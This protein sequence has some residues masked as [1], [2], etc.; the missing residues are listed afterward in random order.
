MTELYKKGLLYKGYTI[1]PYSPAAGTGLS[2]HELNQ[3]GCYRDVKDTTCTALVPKSIRDEK[4]E[5]L[6][7][8]V[9]GDRV[10]HGMDDHTLDVALEYRAGCG[11]RYPLRTRADVTIPIRASSAYRRS[12]QVT[13]V[14]AY[15][16]KK[17]EELPIWTA[18]TATGRTFRTGS[19]GEF[20]G[21]ELP[22]IRVRAADSVDQTRWAM[23]S[24]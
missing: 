18:T 7:D 3:P 8:G 19:T 13:C 11:A 23:R 4:S 6:F 5:K 12:G 22:G 2:N 15:F 24:G 21:K 16:P 10:F 1:Q 20:L 17:N 9:D 14:T